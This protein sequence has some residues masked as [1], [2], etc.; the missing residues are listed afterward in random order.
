[1]HRRLLRGGVVLAAC[2]LLLAT[3]VASA[4]AAPNRTTLRGSAPTW[5]DARHRAGPADSAGTVQ[6]R[7]YLGWRDADGAA[8]FARAVSDPRSSSYGK[9][10]TPGEFPSRFAPSGR[11]SR[12]YGR[13]SRS[14]AST[15]PT[16]RATTTTSPLRVRSPRPSP[17]LGRRSRRTRS[18]ASASARR[19]VTSRFRARL[20]VRSRAWWVSTTV[21]R[22][23][24]R[25]PLPTARR[26]RPRGSAMRRR[27]RTTGRSCCPR[28]RSRPGSRI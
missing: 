24:A 16:R 13:G 11:R 4:S 3:G 6:F 26:R 19:Q 2:A 8:A 25:T 5:A 18:T 9:F 7:V 20:Q 22:S 15:S 10:L 21:R 27:C 1:M 12:A 14:R 17:R 23:S 28:T